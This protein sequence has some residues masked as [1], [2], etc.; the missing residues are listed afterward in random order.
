MQIIDLLFDNNKF[1]IIKKSYNYYDDIYHFLMSKRIA[2]K[3]IKDIN[4][5][6]KETYDWSKLIYP[7]DLY[8]DDDN[9][10]K[11]QHKREIFRKNVEN[12]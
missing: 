11:K 5:I 3:T 7:K 4:N 10:I 12:R 6:N 9:R 1:I 2:K 8:N